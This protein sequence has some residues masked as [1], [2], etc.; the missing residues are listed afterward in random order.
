[1][2][3]TTKVSIFGAGEIGTPLAV[4][5]AQN[6]GFEV[7]VLDRSEA[8]LD[9]FRAL[10]GEAEN[11]VL[12]SH[13]DDIYRALKR[14]DIVVAAVPA[15][16]AVEVAQA[17]V[18]ANA[19]YLDFLSPTAQIRE[20]L[21]P[22]AKSRAVLTG[23]GVSPGLITNVAYSLAERLAPVTDLTIRVGAI[24]RY[25]A[26]RLGY[27]QIWNIDG[28]I[29]EY[30]KPCAAL[31]GGQ[32]ASLMPLEEYGRIVIDGV[33]YEEFVTSGGI[34]D[35]SVF[36]GL[37]QNNLTFKTIRYP[38]HLNYM[39]FLLDD[40]GLRHRRDMLRSLLYNGLPIIED[41]I[42]ILSVTARGTR[43]SQP[44]ESTVCHSF[45]PDKRRSTFNALNSVAAAY[46]ASLISMLASG[47]L[48]TNGVI[49]HHKVEPT[50]LLD[51][52]YMR[53]LLRETAR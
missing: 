45:Q 17:A 30:T 52:P 43:G 11:L 26:N 42:L 46:A 50:T 4:T 15:A 8:A 10:H 51:S 19:H 1:M 23:C 16:S 53:S 13:Q 5:L 37:T 34:E 2:A 32:P 25:P 48:P 14:Q 35:L 20:T 29:D 18:K 21:E 3:G 27:G 41:D 22:L 49:A 40:L 39:Q 6:K 7:Q 33:T 9:R 38:G 36:A 12:V 28:L 31:R 44:I 47:A 24:P